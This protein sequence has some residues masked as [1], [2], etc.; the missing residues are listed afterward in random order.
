MPECSLPA[1]FAPSQPSEC[2]QAREV[3]VGAVTELGLKVAPKSERRNSSNIDIRFVFP[4]TNRLLY[5]QDVAGATS[6]AEN[7]VDVTLDGTEI[8]L[9][10][11]ATGYGVIAWDDNTMLWKNHRDGSHYVLKRR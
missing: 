7:A 6:Q 4:S 1:P 3:S 9:P 8:V 11:P 5:C 10:S 2:G